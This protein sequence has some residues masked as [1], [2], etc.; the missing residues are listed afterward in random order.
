MIDPDIMMMRALE[1]A[2]SGQGNVSPNPMVGCVITKDG[3]IIGEGYHRKYGGPHAEVN[4]VNSVKTTSLLVGSEVFVTL[5]P[6]S[7][8]GKTPPCADLLIKNQVR[9]VWIANTDPNPLVS[10]RGIQKLEAAGIEVVTGLRADEG[11]TVNKRFF[12]FMRRQRPYIILKWAETADG[13]IAR[14]NFDSRWISNAYSRQLVHQWRAYEDAI[15]VGTNTALHDDPKLNVREWTGKDPLRIVIDRNLKLPE[16]LQLFSDGKPTI[17]FNN[18]DS[19]QKESVE[20]IRV[21]EK[22]PLACMMHSL[23]QKNIQSVIVEGGASLLNSFLEEGLWDE[24]RLFRSPTAFGEGIASP[25]KSAF[26]Y[27]LTQPAEE[28][29]VEGDKLII[30]NNN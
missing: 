6:C 9:K 8:H 7:H 15:M 4:A 21:E 16:T 28:H 29:D 14:K 22:N 18:L 26:G 13:Y 25:T 5:E 1:L 23:Y 17:C 12:T 27:L 30:I 10:G 3:Q 19:T 24:I 11:E 20:Y 2:Q